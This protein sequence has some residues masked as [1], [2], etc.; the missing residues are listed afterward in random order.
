MNRQELAALCDEIKP[1]DAALLES[2]Q[3]RLDSLTKPPGSLGR[4]EEFAR[5]LAAIQGT[6]KPCIG[7]KRVYTLAG[8][9]GVT[10]EGVSAFPSEVTPQMVLNFLGAGAAINVLTKHVGSEIMV[11]DMGDGF[12]VVPLVDAY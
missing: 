5:R 7:K 4:L 11:V 1:L 9:H 6:V 8:D 3:E 10:E 2:A 12:P